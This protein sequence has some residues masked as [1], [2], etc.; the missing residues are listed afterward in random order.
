MFYNDLL[1]VRVMAF[2][3]ISTKDTT[4]TNKMTIAELLKHDFDKGSLHLYDS[5]GNEIYYEASN[6]FWVK[7]EFDSNGNKI[8]YET[9][10]IDNR[11]KPSCEGKIVEIEGRTYKLV[12]LY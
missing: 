6:G 1:N 9:S 5:N 12:E 10:N 11:P 4:K 2:T 7:R 8:Y 3:Y